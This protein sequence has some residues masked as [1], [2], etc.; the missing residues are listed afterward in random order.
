MVTKG[1]L[2]GILEI[3]TQA[4]DAAGAIREMGEAAPGIRK[5]Y[6]S[7]SGEGYRVLGIACREMGDVRSISKKDEAGM[8]FL[9]MLVFFDPSQGGGGGGRQ[10]A[11]GAGRLAEDHHRRQPPGGGRPEPPDRFRE[12]GCPEPDRN[13]TG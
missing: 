9:G 1:P 6:E 2:A 13:S 12:S 5:Q 4:E 3:C 7:F 10:A 8:T 11:P